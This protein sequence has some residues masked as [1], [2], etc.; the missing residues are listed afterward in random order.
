MARSATGTIE[1]RRLVDGTRAFHLR[2]LVHG[3]SS[4]S[5]MSDRPARVAAVA[6]GAK[7]LRVPSSGTSRPAFAPAYDS[8]GKLPR[9]EGQA[10]LRIRRGSRITQ[11]AGCLRRSRA[12]RGQSQSAPT[13]RTTTAGGCSSTSCR[14]SDPT[15]WTTST[16][17]YANG[18]R[19]GIR[20]H[21]QPG[22][23]QPLSRATH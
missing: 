22:A 10:Q 9:I 20:T 11:G 3:R 7:P 15:D 17:P 8:A 12:R 13:L 18:T 16:T 23:T 2:F 21:P 1:A 4:W 6:A 5:C 19:S 14:S